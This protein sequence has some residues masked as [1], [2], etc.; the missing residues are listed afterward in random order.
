MANSSPIIFARLPFTPAPFRNPPGYISVDANV[1][2]MKAA[3]RPPNRS[4]TKDGRAV[5]MATGSVQDLIDAGIMFC[6]TPDQVYDQIAG[7]ARSLR[8]H[9]QSFDRWAMPGFMDA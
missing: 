5:N 8:R 3:G 7:F 6:G 4:F 9:G 2:L 1:Q